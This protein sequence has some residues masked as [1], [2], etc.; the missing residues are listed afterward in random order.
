[1]GPTCT[2]IEPDS[3]SNFKPFP[4]VFCWINI[5]E[6]WNR[7]TLTNTSTKDIGAA[8]VQSLVLQKTGCLDCFWLLQSKFR[9]DVDLCETSPTHPNLWVKNVKKNSDSLVFPVQKARHCAAITW[10]P[11]QISRNDRPDYHRLPHSFLHLP[12]IC[13]P[14]VQ[15]EANL[16]AHFLKPRI[17][18]AFLGLSRW[19]VILAWFPVGTCSPKR[20]RAERSYK[21]TRA[22]CK[23]LFYLFGCTIVYNLNKRHWQLDVHLS[24]IHLGKW[25]NPKGLKWSALVS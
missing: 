24:S 7:S 11:R 20:N 9:R 10:Y 22:T 14:V 5:I 15:P 18:V 23:L 19:R 13:C 12:A 16:I 6:W 25:Q 17:A 21:T 8:R 1:M 2:K 3:W 4:S